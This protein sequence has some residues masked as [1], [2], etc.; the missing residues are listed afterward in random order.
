MV[1]HIK[2]DCAVEAKVLHMYFCLP[3]H[4]QNVNICMPGSS[5]TF[6]VGQQNANKQKVKMKK[7]L[8]NRSIHL[9]EFNEDAILFNAQKKKGKAHQVSSSKYITNWV[10]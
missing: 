9:H 3:A 8:K 5:L 10:V 7:K 2:E 1:E 6:I 4:H